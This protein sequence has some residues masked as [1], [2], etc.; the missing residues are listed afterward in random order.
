MK[1]ADW[2][3]QARPSPAEVAIARRT[4][5]ESADVEGA[6]YLG[7]LLVAFQTKGSTS[8]TT[9][10]GIAILEK[11]PRPLIEKWCNRLLE[12]DKRVSGFE[13]MRVLEVSQRV[14]GTGEPGRP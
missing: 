2:E 4:I 14:L 5:A 12:N 10:D 7:F 6:A 13:R 8:L 1:Q 3:P 11:L 9:G